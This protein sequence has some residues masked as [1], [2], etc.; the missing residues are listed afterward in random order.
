M[1][2]TSFLTFLFVACAP[3][4]GSPELTESPLGD[5]PTVNVGFPIDGVTIAMRAVRYDSE[6]GVTYLGNPVAKATVSSGYA[7]L[8]LPQRPPQRD[9]VSD[10]G[11]PVSYA[12]FAYSDFVTTADDYHGVAD[13]RVT[14]FSG[15][16]GSKRGWYVESTDEDGTRTWASTDKMVSV[17]G[18]L[19]V[20]YSVGVNGFRGDL[21]EFETQLVGFQSSE[22]F[23]EATAELTTEFHTSVVGAPTSLTT[24]PDGT[25]V[26][27]LHPRI[28]VDTDADGVYGGDDKVVGEL[29]AGNL[30]V[31]YQ[32]T[33]G[34]HTPEDALSYKAEGTIPGWAAW[35]V[36][37]DE[38]TP[39][40]IDASLA[41]STECAG[42]E[43]PDDDG[44]NVED[45]GAI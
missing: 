24:L 10:S 31:Y 9:K 35:A 38:R 25:E 29:C 6:G 13:D 1:R 19:L 43:P 21:A 3:E 28:F 32:W 2:F 34:A 4:A 22:G 11:A 14:F 8:K 33:E 26:A 37:G 7:L 30:P 40:P 27:V 45:T 44:S 5:G 39:L 17:T 36:A 15:K 12:I 16:S 18:S 20:N 42:S 23:A 41:A